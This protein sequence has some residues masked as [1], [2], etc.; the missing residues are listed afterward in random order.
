MMGTA[1]P[2]YP[3]VTLEWEDFDG[4]D[5]P[6]QRYALYRLCACSRCEGRGRVNFDPYPPERCSQCRGEGK[7]KELLATAGSPQAMGLALVTLAQEGEWEECPLGLWDRQGE[8][9]SKWLVKPWLPSPR[10]VSDA[11]R[12]LRASRRP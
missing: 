12:T 3:T 5:D 7:I 10:N 4:R 6:E 8:V 11:G 2:D 9:G 1:S